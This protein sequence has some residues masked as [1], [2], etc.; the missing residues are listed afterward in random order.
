MINDIEERF[1]LR[2]KL[3]SP[4][5]IKSKEIVIFWTYHK[6]LH[7]H[8]DVGKIAWCEV[9]SM[10]KAFVNTLIPGNGR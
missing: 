5:I 6:T 2:A 4:P 10:M 8:I 1:D 3:T 9:A 7:C